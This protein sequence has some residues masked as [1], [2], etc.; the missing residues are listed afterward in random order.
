[1]NIRISIR[2]G[3]SVTRNREVCAFVGN[4]I[5]SWIA[6]YERY[7]TTS[8][9]KFMPFKK[10]STWWLDPNCKFEIKCDGKTLYVRELKK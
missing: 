6:E 2:G 7:S 4:N 3:K 8:L 5:N 9:S 10:E 1:M